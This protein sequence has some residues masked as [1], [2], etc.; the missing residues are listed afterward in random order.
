MN[1]SEFRDL[2]REAELKQRQLARLAHVSPGAVSRWCSGTAKDRL[3]PPPH[4]VALVAAYA[5]LSQRERATLH[6]RLAEIHGHMVCVL[7][8]FVERGW[9]QRSW[10]GG[11]MGWTRDV[12]KAGRWRRREIPSAF[13]SVVVSDPY[14]PTEKGVAPLYPEPPADL[15]QTVKA[16]RRRRK[17]GDGPY[18]GFV[19]KL[20]AR[21][22][23]A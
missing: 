1:P 7:W 11:V 15:P 9:A 16:P 19:V 4:I 17:K 12:A 14:W 13:G 2:L 6:A 3:P 21:P 23:R 20:P 10:D 5:L 22:V 18:P 8:S